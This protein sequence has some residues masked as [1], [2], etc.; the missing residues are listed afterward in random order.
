MAAS[1]GG[2]TTNSLKNDITGGDDV[3]DR[4]LVLR[5]LPLQPAKLL[6]V[7]RT[8]PERTLVERFDIEPFS[9]FS[10]K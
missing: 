9:D 1:N 4:D 7:P 5:M 2:A 3:H 10:A 6:L 8:V